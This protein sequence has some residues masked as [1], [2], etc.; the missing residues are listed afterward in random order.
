M[1]QNG[2]NTAIPLE[3]FS[4]VV[5]EIYDCAL[6]P[7]RWQETV[8]LIAKLMLSRACTLGIHDWEHHRAEMTF[9]VGIET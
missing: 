5:E 2:K 9:M 3:T 7:S 4:Q 8:G 1:A 6:E